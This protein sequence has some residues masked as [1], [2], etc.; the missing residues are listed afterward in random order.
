[1]RSFDITAIQVATKVSETA[2]AMGSTID[3]RNYD[4]LI[5]WLKYAKGTEAGAYIT[6][7]YLI[8]PSGDEYQH[9]EWSNDNEALVNQKK[10]KLTATGNNYIV[11][12]VRGVPIVKLYQHKVSGTVTGTL[13]ADYSLLRANI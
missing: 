5:I 11:L 6:P 4:Y 2:T 12:D 1:M 10:F 7:S 3:V 8:A 13:K 9:M